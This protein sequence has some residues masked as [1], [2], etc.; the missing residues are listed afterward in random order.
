MRRVSRALV[1]VAAVLAQAAAPAPLQQAVWDAVQP[2]LAFPAATDE[3]LPVDGSTTARWVVRR[4]RAD[5]GALVAEVLA[6]PLNRETQTQA[7]HDM[8]A[9]QQEVFAAERR[10]QV[11]FERA[12]RE[13]RQ[14][15]SAIVRGITLD[16]EGV[17]GDR[18]DAEERMTI[19]VESGAEHVVRLEGIEAPTVKGGVSGGPWIVTM[20]AREVRTPGASPARYFPAQAIVYIASA[21]PLVNP[22]PSQIFTVRTTSAD[23][24]AVVAVTLRGNRDLID[25]VVTRADWSR[26]ASRVR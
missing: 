18:A 21:R 23:R 8:A 26:I 24:G 15:G 10:A 5:E 13:A 6:N 19:E 14:S 4:A 7:A 11:E 12:S 9:I 22:G 17:A 20:P 3:N 25:A 1:L 2:V 16:D